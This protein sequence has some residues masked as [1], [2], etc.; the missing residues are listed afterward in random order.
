MLRRLYARL[1][2]DR[3]QHVR[4][5]SVET[6]DM[7]RLDRVEAR[8]PV[9]DIARVRAD[10]PAPP[11]FLGWDRAGADGIGGDGRR[12]R[13][14]RAHRSMRAAFK[15]RSG[16]LAVD[17][18]AVE[19]REQLVLPVARR[20][21]DI[22][23]HGLYAVVDGVGGEVPRVGVRRRIVHRLLERAARAEV[24]RDKYPDQ[25]WV[26]YPIGCPLMPG[27]KTDRER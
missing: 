7:G 18:A 19:Q 26:R 14:S 11:H 16:R 9:R 20:V 17:E 24:W 8:S 1:L 4:H 22:G 3:G 10:T 13:E 25:S 12:I 23:L 15:G 27:S 21:L 2:R 5:Y 6:I